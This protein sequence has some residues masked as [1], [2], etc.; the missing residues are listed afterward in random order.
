LCNRLLA[1]LLSA[2]DHSVDPQLANEPVLEGDGY[3]SIQR[4]V[5][6]TVSVRTST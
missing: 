5:Y 3:T 4:G 2:Y 1:I 6:V